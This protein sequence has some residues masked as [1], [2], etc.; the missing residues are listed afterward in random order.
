MNEIELP[1]RIKGPWRNALILTYGADVPFFEN[2][3]WS[4]FSTGCRNKIV[5][6]DGQRYLEGCATYARSGLVRHLNH[7]YVADGILV[8]RAAH[9]KVIL[10]TNSERG[11]LLLGSG[12][13]S[14]QGYASGG[15]Q[16]T[17]YEYDADNPEALN[18]FAAVRDVVDYVIEYRYIGKSAQR[19][20]THM[21]EK[22][23]WLFQSPAGE[24]QPVR[25]NLNRSFMHQ[26]HEVVADRPL[27]ELWV[28]SPFYDK[29]AIA[30][31]TLLATLRPEHTTLLVQPGYTSICPTALQRVLDQ[32][33]GSCCV[34]PFEKPDGS[35]YVHAKLYLLKLHDRAIC[36]QGSPNLSRSAMMWTPP[37]G[38]IEMVNLLVGDRP[39]FDGL[40]ET[41][42]I[43]PA[44]K[45]LDLLDLS[46]QAAETTGESAVEGCRLTSGEWFNDRLELCFQGVLPDLDEA[47]LLIGR[48]SFP[49]HVL[50]QG[51]K[52]LVIRLSQ[53]AAQLL[54][55]P[56][57]VAIRWGERTEATASN[58]I[59]VCNRSALD[60]EL[61]ETDSRRT[62][63]RIGDLDL[64]DE[65]FEELLA[66]LNAALVFDDQG[67]WQLAGRSLP[68]D[69]AEDDEALRLD[70]ADVDYDML[71]RHPKIQ[72]YLSKGA[73]RQG[74]ART[75]LQ[76]ILSAIT[77]HF[78]GLTHVSFRARLVEKALKS[79][80]EEEI[81]TEEGREEADETN[82]RP[83]SHSQRIGRI[84]KS[85]IRRYLRGIRSQGFQ[86]VAG[87]EVVVKNY[88][89]F[90]HLLW[91][92]FSTE[93]V[94][95][96]FIVD[97]L[98]KMWTFFW[99]SESHTGYLDTLTKEQRQQALGWIEEHHADAVVVA[100]LYYAARLARTEEWE[101]RRFALRDFWREMLLALPFALTADTLEESW[102]LVGDLLPDEPPVP[103]AIAE[104]LV[105][106]A[107][108][109]TRQ[110][111]L[112]DL[113]TEKGYSTRS[114]GFEDVK[115]RRAGYTSAM[116]VR[117]LVV[118]SEDALPTFEE[119]LAVLR[120]WM[121]F[122][123][124]DYYRI[125]CP[126]RHGSCT[127]FF[128]EV[129]EE[130]G[131]YWARDQGDDP[132]DF[133]R[134]IRVP[135]AEWDHGLSLLQ[136]A[137]AEVDVTLDL[138]SLEVDLTT[139]REPPTGG[140]GHSE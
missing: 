91:R 118:R 110:S 11:R 63:D 107:R 32:F 96:E 56:R 112:R 76:I 102:L 129:P 75:R 126:D 9:A 122:E 2:A 77:D 54:E 138:E 21:W 34:R 24:W 98:L 133:D 103:P 30:L 55:R 127:I 67:V 101:E 61:E 1:N 8:P 74:Y 43:Q 108:F 33:D 81:E 6:A 69:G 71:R 40:L 52:A 46:Y 53:E 28:L 57:S 90:A 125:T 106:L 48:R 49:L 93:W 51:Q 31:E 13:L 65:E 135:T 25:H 20:I 39:A 3:L 37:Q 124:L 23:P 26:L 44:V 132:V 83:R 131:T 79:V 50:R 17:E 89:I 60:A 130:S 119:A 105:R 58:P 85:F 41:F 64:D 104:E 80:E 15:E 10:L 4:Q 100:A 47:C 78:R 97:A 66:E 92:L 35:P 86:E 59:F 62:L 95:P 22:T 136:T 84:L 18:A 29:D 134:P 88:V 68:S 94:E 14:W 5:L 42:D 109:E 120:R 7:R 38:N 72:Q 70:Y 99:G 123:Q 19:R 140:R 121:R 16:F 45:S 137:A 113:E 111:F 12:N 114:C 27:E 87:F 82:Q 139:F 73:G 115:V 128:Y 116:P 36:L 117:C